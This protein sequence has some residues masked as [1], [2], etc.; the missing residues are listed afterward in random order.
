MDDNVRE[1]RFKTSQAGTG[2]DVYYCKAN[3]RCYIRQM[4]NIEDPPTV[5]WLSCTKGHDNCGWSGY[6]ASAPLRAG[7]V[8]RVLKNDGSVDF[9]EKI[10]ANSWDRDTHAKKVGAFSW[11]GEKS[12][13]MDY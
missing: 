6:E 3:G 10:E 12:G 1:L 13:Q 8:M 9:E 11:E 5:F 4:T 7:L 2:E